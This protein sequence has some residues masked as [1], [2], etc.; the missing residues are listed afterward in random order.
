MSAE[1]QTSL[2]LLTAEVAVVTGVAALVAAGLAWAHGRARLKAAEA[3]R[4]AAARL[5]GEG[6]VVQTARDLL[7][8]F[9]RASL[10]RDAEVLAGLPA[11]LLSLRQVIEAAAAPAAPE[12]DPAQAQEAW[13]AERARLQAKVEGLEQQRAQIQQHLDTALGTINALVQEYGRGRGQEVAPTAEALLQ[14]LLQVGAAAPAF[15]AAGGAASAEDTTSRPDIKAKAGAQAAEEGM[16]GLS[17]NDQVVVDNPEEPPAPGEPEVVPPASTPVAAADIDA[18][19]ED[20][21]GAAAVEPKSEAASGK[22]T[23]GDV[24]VTSPQAE[25]IDDQGLDLSVPIEPLSAHGPERGYD[26]PAP[27]PGEAGKDELDELDIDAL[28][29]AELRRQARLLTPTEAPVDDLYDLA[30]LDEPGT[31]K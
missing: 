3:L 17:I 29:D 16:M 5:P 11:R 14:A 26:A 9:A 13:E 20:V 25:G 10:T 15:A 18:L 22:G 28:L 24:A 23:I 8:E 30:R 31:K 21:L 6:E 19:L 12:V 1:I 27:S 4:D 2:F 7:G